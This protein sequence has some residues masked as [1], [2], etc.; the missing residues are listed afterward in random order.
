MAHLIGLLSCVYAL[1][2]LQ[3]LQV[4]ETRAAHVAGVRLLSG[5]NENVGPEVCHLER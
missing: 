3:G 2:T 1:V 4:T 5:V